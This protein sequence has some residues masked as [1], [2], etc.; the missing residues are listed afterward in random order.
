MDSVRD[1]ILVRFRAALD[2]AYGERIDRV[3]LFGSRAREDARADS[4]YDVAVFLN[5]YESFWAETGRIADFETDI[6]FDT[7]MSINALPFKASAYADRTAFMDEV[8]RD[9]R[10]L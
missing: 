6:L 10:E 5:E 9:G 1:P 4:D 3:V 8:R 2:R 7:G